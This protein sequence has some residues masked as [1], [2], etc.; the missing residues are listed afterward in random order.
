M[1]WLN[2]NRQDIQLLSNLFKMGLRDRFLGSSLGMVWAIASPVLMLSIFTFVFGFV[3]KSKLPGA[4]TSLSYIIWLISGYGPWLAISEGITSSTMS[5]SSNSSIVKNL[6]F[7]TELLPMS[8]GLMG[9]VP[10][11]VTLVFLTGLIVVDGQAPSWNW[12]FLLPAIVVQ[13]ALVI[14][15]GFFLSALNVFIRDV[16]TALPNI[17]LLILFFS[18]IFYALS[19]FPPVLQVVSQFN[20]FYILTEMYRQPLLY[21]RL[22]EIWSVLYLCFVTAVTFLVGLKVFRRVKPYFDSRL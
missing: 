9:I 3:F 16:Q 20:P 13:F 10:L 1:K 22:P 19:A 5:V 6:A 21:D 8:G 17:L 12:L 18:P 7:K 15:I 4:E 14:G 11:T 2:I